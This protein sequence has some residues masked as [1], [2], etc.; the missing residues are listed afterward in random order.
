MR[1]EKDYYEILGV[2]RDASTEQVKRAFRK[3]AFQYHPDHNND[4][5]AEER[6]KEINEAYEVISDAEKRAFY[7]QYGRVATSGGAGG[8]D[9]FNFGGFGDLFEA[10][11]GGATTTA[12]S[13]APQK[14]ADL[15]SKLSLSFEEAVFGTK[16]EIEIER[17]ENCPVCRG[18]GSRPGTSPQKCP[19]CN[20]SGQVRRSQ[21]SLF[22]H[23]VQ[24]TAC[25]RCNGEGTS[26]T[27]PC[28][29]CKGKGRVR[30][31]RK[32][33]F[34]VPAGVDESYRMRL[35]GEGQ[36]GVYGGLSGDIYI[37]FSVDSHEVFVRKGNDIICDLT[38]NFAQ[39]AL[40]DNLEVPT[41]DGETMLKIPP[42]TQNGKVF[43][44]KGK[45]VPRLDGRGR[46]DQ[47]VQI[48]IM[49]PQSLDEKQKKLFEELAKTLPGA[50]ISGDGAK[51]KKG[52]FKFGG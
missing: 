42:G 41:L 11:F 14:G 22:G 4:T 2:P 8:F 21:E 27:D 31:K 24:V 25:S 33:A 35:S 32:L 52:R 43:H 30:V 48:R 47:L 29:E 10:F 28:P 36:A 12:R 7:N 17:V 16:K 26:I 15:Q 51:E 18:V 44:I 9:S 3:L 19:D 1:A 20:G 49:T 34:T 37:T 6:F 40:G 13:R 46:G 5:E 38:I 39:A 23:F 45:G 50:E